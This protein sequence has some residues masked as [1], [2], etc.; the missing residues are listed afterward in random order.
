MVSMT[1][2]SGAAAREQAIH[3]RVLD[4]ADRIAEVLFG[5]IMVPTSTGSL[6]VAALAARTFAR[7]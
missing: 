3:K 4:P 7:C 5:L 1:D 2:D 6:G